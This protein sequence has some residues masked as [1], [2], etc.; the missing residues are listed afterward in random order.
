MAQQKKVLFVSPMPPPAGGIATWTKRIMSAQLPGGWGKGLVDTRV[1]LGRSVFSGRKNYLHELFRAFRI[2]L[3]L[4]V[5]LLDRDFSVVHI[6]CSGSKQGMLRDVFCALLVLTFRRR[7]VVHYRCTTSVVIEGSQ[8]RFIFRILNKLAHVVIVL[9]GASL[10][11]AEVN[12]ASAVRLI[13]NFIDFDLFQS[14][15]RVQVREVVKRIVFVGGGVLTKGCGV[16][17]EAAR[18]FPEIQFFIVGSRSDWL[19]AQELTNNVVIVGEVDYQAVLELLSNSDLFLFPTFFPAEGFANALLEAM[20]CGLPCVATNWAANADMLE[21]SGG[22]IVPPSDV[23]ATVVAIREL[24][25]CSRRQVASTWNVEKVA[26]S[27]LDVHVLAQY[28]D[29]YEF[30]CSI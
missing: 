16:L 7:V 14:L 15:K 5:Q 4:S 21:S 2:F 27:Y 3:R 1:L 6:N 22:V 18:V 8:A 19:D 10:S 9:N 24:L 30:A 23:E 29:A 20:A 28:I 12:G 13:P 17:I 26:R 25:D 11:D